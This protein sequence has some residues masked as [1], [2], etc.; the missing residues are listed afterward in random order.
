MGEN[1]TKMSK[2]GTGAK[3]DISRPD[4]IKLSGPDALKLVCFILFFLLAGQA[5]AEEWIYYDTNSVGDL[6]Y[7]RSRIAKVGKDVFAV[8]TKNVLSADAKTKYYS[9]LQGIG[10]AP[11]NPAFLSYYTELLEL[12][13]AGKK[14]RNVSVAFYNEIGGVLY[15]SP[16]GAAGLWN[17][18]LP[19][20]VGEKLLDVLS[21]EIVDPKEAAAAPGIEAPAAS[22][23]D[24]KVKTET[25]SRPPA[26]VRESARDGRFIAYNNETVLDTGTNLMW[27]AKDNGVDIHWLD[28]KNYCKEYRGGGYADWRMPTIEELEELYDRK[29]PRKQTCSPKYDIYLTPLID[30]SCCCPWAAQTK[31]ADAAYFN[32]DSG[33]RDWEEEAYEV[34]KWYR[35]LPVRNAR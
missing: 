29:S 21:W 30:L 3:T 9:I 23:A 16:T 2:D 34:Q 26:V 27:A 5:G 14:M 10:K 35:A 7:D 25:A 1:F 12:D 6:Y 20:S 8:W 15:S 32:F 18:I 19:R 22:E 31:D 33:R 11:A 24:K 4:P 13:R 17:D 28:A